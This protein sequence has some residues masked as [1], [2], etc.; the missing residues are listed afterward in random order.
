[1]AKQRISSLF[2]AIIVFILPASVTF[3]TARN[4]RAT[5]GTRGPK[6]NCVS[7]SPSPKPA[8]SPSPYPDDVIKGG[9]WPSWLAYSL[10]PSSTLPCT[11]HMCFMPLLALMLLLTVC[12]SPNLMI[13]R[14]ETLQPP[15]MPKSHRHKPC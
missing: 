15:F 13:S 3:S 6:P 1:M 7:P 4:Y 2:L 12:P 9:Y 5:W 10:P 11:S 8:P 14:W